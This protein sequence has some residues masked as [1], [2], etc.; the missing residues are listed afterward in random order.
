MIKKMISG[1]VVWLVLF[2]I[3]G[4]AQ[5][6]LTRIG[7][8]SYQGAD[9]SLIYDDDAELTWLDYTYQARNGWS[10][11]DQWAASLNGPGVLQYNFYS[12]V[13]VSWAEAGW[14][15]PA[16]AEYYAGVESKSELGHLFH[17]ELELTGL[18]YVSDADLNASEFDNLI[19]YW[20]WTEEDLSAFWT[21]RAM[22]FALHQ[23]EQNGI[24][25]YARA[26]GVAVH[27]GNVLVVP[28]PSAICLLS[29]GLIGLLRMRKK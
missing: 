14:R 7:T 2:V 23:G 22:A 28:V 15:L 10:A 16:I 3:T 17:I 13:S 11:T 26:Y 24:P 27:P 18:G 9:Y 5:A 12:G 6:S 1:V 25:H 20:Y 29:F 4:M 21:G 19:A 8:A